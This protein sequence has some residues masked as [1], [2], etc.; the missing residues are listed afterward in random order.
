MEWIASYNDQTELKQF[1]NGKEH[2]FKEINQEKLKQFA[3]T[4]NNKIQAFVDLDTGQIHVGNKILEFPK[5]KD[6]EFRLIYFRRVK[7]VI[8]SPEDSS[9]SHYIGWQTTIKDRNYKRIISFKDNK[10]AIT[11]E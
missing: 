7:Q 9:V 4:E 10:I 2:L 1:E 6:V 11:C 5:F 3:L 8:G